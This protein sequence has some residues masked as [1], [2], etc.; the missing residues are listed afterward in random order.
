MM[1]RKCI[2]ELGTKFGEMTVLKEA[3]KPKSHYMYECI[4]SCGKELIIRA[5]ELVNGRS[6]SCKRC[7]LTILRTQRLLKKKLEKSN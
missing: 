7:A 4:C 2:I 6:Q 3:G 1:K 5:A